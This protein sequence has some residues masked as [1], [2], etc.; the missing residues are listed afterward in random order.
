MMQTHAE[1]SAN[2]SGGPSDLGAAS[3]CACGGSA[4]MAG[5]C[6]S[7]SEEARSLQR[8]AAGSDALGLTRAP[9]IVHDVLRSP[10][11][12]LDPA[13]R[14]GMEARFGH[15]FGQ[16]P[17]HHQAPALSRSGLTIGPAHDASER[18]ADHLA[19]RVTHASARA[20]A[21]PDG[22]GRRSTS[23]ESA[24]TPTP[25]RSSRRAR[26]T[27][28]RTPWASA[29]SSAR[30]P[31]RRAPRPGSTC[32]PT[33]YARRQQSGPGGGPVG[34][35][36]VQRQPL[37]EGRNVAQEQG[38]NFEKWSPE[39]E[40]QYRRA[41]EIGAA[42]ALQ[43]CRTHGKPAC[44]MVLTESELWAMYVAD[45][46]GQIAPAKQPGTPADEHSGTGCRLHQPSADPGRTDR[47][48]RHEIPPAP[49]PPPRRPRTVDGD[50]RA[51]A[52][53]ASAGIGAGSSK[54]RRRRHSRGVPRLCRVG[55]GEVRTFQ[56]K[57]IARRFRHPGGSPHD[58]HAQLPFVLADR[59]DKT[60]PSFRASA[61]TRQARSRFDRGPKL[62]L[63][64]SLSRGASERW[65]DSRH[66]GLYRS[67]L[68]GPAT[69]ADSA[70][71]AE[72]EEDALALYHST[73]EPDTPHKG[74]DD[75][76]AARPALANGLGGRR[77]VT[78]P[79]RCRS[80]ACRGN[81]P[82]HSQVRDG[83][84]RRPRA[85]S[86]ALRGQDGLSGRGFQPGFPGTESIINRMVDQSEDEP[87]R[88]KKLRLPARLDIQ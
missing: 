51:P 58:L 26:S 20:A 38:Y 49:A 63:S 21:V 31:T 76:G 34:H 28:W 32:S 74:A 52:A 6:K 42:D 70:A 18:E 41:G 29:S 85:G 87:R 10:G 39:I 12:P 59:S 66:P 15:T 69:N 77:P 9:P 36:V 67:G 33:G 88:R 73:V 11:Q 17:V 56:R 80:A 23:A 53:G 25:A 27:P 83:E 84:L 3:K 8:R 75:V 71:D 60:D 14:A 47:S 1:N 5:R 22:M 68:A 50:R 64:L 44:D 72:A 81:S 7:C 16:V 19:D 45:Q 54:P 82:D 37:G 57:L 4:S 62:V 61:H 35:G 65:P 86:G 40:A 13:T 46:I 78:M 24:F 2:T 43:R 55:Y 79:T 48:S 30:E